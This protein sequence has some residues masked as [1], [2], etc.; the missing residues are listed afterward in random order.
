MED[1]SQTQQGLIKDTKNAIAAAKYSQKRYFRYTSNFH[2]YDEI[3]KLYYESR[4]FWR[5]ALLI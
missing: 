1:S 5:K 2:S 3:T 4:W